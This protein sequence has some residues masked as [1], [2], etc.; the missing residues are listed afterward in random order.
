MYDVFY[1]SVMDMF[2]PTVWAQA[3]ATEVAQ[4]LILKKISAITG[5]ITE[6]NGVPL[7]AEP[8]AYSAHA[9]RAYAQRPRIC[10]YRE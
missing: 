6:L 2:F 10:T 9:Q 8:G 1:A 3:D 7:S 4:K 5:V